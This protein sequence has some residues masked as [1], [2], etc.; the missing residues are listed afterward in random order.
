MNLT[1]FFLTFLCLFFS[2][3]LCLED[4]V[5]A[6]HGVAA[7][8]ATQT[9]TESGEESIETK[10]KPK[11]VKVK[12]IKK[13]TKDWDKLSENELEKKW[14][15][16]DDEQELEHEFERIQRIQAKK[17]QKVSTVLDSN[18]PAQISKLSL[19][20]LPSASLTCP[21]SVS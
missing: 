1:T 13:S 16:G 14:E 7:D 6:D 3:I 12:K 2:N 20:L 18:D 15:E 5:A 19:P 4:G 8:L 17:S 9:G 11:P 21:P 10:P